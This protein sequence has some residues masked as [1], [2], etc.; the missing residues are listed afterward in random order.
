[1]RAS[2]LTGRATWLAA[3]LADLTRRALSGTVLAVFQHSAYLDLDG[4]IVALVEAG[5]ARGPFTITVDTLAGVTEISQTE[6]VTL[7][8]GR[9]RIGAAEI[10]LTAAGLWD[11]VLPAPAPGAP[12]RVVR[13][14]AVEELLAAAPV[15]SITPLLD[16]MPPAGPLLGPLSQGLAMLADL[17]D[18]PGSNEQAYRAA[19]QRMAGRGPGLTPSGDDLLMGIVLALR[20]WPH[21]A[22]AT[23]VADRLVDAAMP[24]TTRI[25]AAYLDAAR[26]GSAGEPWHALIRGLH[27]AAAAR[28]AVRRLARVGETS[29]A[30]ALT[31]FCWV[32]RRL[33]A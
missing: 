10:D 12:Q 31:G 24:K 32:W 8:Q 2:R 19:A 30:D 21:A 16:A 15:G 20:T 33:A 28:A 17:L 23:G 29:G 25:S 22:R 6:P 5:L 18:D 13:E 3:P 4:R 11:P 1:V 26:R 7:D 14:A 9:L 27:D